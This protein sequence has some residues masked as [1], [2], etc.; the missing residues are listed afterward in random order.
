MEEKDRNVTDDLFQSKLRDLEVDVTPQDW[1]MI[2]D[3]LPRA[4]SLPLYRRA[5]FWAAAAVSLLVAMSGLY[6]LENRTETDPVV[7]EIQRLTDELEKPYT[8]AP[9]PEA[10]KPPVARA[11]Q[12]TAASRVTIINRD[13]ETLPAVEH[14]AEDVDQSPKTT[15]EEPEIP[16]AAS[17]DERQKI[18]AAEES[19]P[20]LKTETQENT[21]RKK[22]KSRKWGFGMGGGAVSVGS[23]NSVPGYMLSTMG[24]RSED[25]LLMNAPSGG[26]AIPKTDVHH[27]KPLSFGLG[28]SY[29]LNN[30]FSLGSGLTYTYLSSDWIT[31]G[32]YK[33]KTTQKLHFV[34]IPLGLT[35]KIAEWQRFNLYASA[36]FQV[37]VNV[38]GQQKEELVH[39]VLQ[40]N[41][42][43]DSE[44]YSVRD[45][46]LLFSANAKVGISYPLLRFVSAYAEAG[47]GYYF[48][49]GGALF[50]KMSKMPTIYSD[51]PLNLTLQAGFRL[52]F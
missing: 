45:R 24:L 49:N 13:E 29:Y 44:V 5:M 2:A 22:V 1:E 48:D 19:A 37:D 14:E 28:V 31:S 47:A 10:V 15:G 17:D 23:G 21:V 43:M 38:G 8:T 39:E 4:A 40:T 18:D 51:K 42:V 25:L 35:Y 27:N 26:E 34:G 16:A 9:E 52:G 46:K 32:K 36:G 30:R 11:L 3:R 41:E 50:D 20:D 12:A 6:F 33:A 7:R